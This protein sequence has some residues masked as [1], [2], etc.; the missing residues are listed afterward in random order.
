MIVTF[1]P[2]INT[3]A[4]A[5]AAYIN[6]LRCVTAACTAAVGAVAG[7]AN[8]TPTTTNLS[9]VPYLNNTGSQD[10]SKNCII[11]VDAN[12]E[13]GGWTTSSNHTLPSSA[14]FTAVNSAAAY[15]YKADFYN[16][17]GKATYPYNKLSFYTLG[18]SSTTYNAAP[19][20]VGG[21]WTVTSNNPTL[22]SWNSYPHIRMVFGSSVNSAW[23]AGDSYT[24]VGL[25]T[26]DNG[27]T[28][29]TSWS[30]NTSQQGLQNAHTA[31]FFANNTSSVY[32]IA[33]TSNY[34]I[35]WQQHS[36]N[37]YASGY[38]N[39]ITIPTTA[40]PV[41][42]WGLYGHMMYG[43]L[44]ET[45][46][47]E[48]SY[49]DNPPW[50]AFQYLSG[51]ISTSLSS[52]FTVAHNF[53]AWMRTIDNNG[54]VSG[55]ATRYYLSNTYQTSGSGPVFGSNAAS[56]TSNANSADPY[57]VG[58]NPLLGLQSPPWYGVDDGTHNP[59][60]NTFPVMPT[61]DPAT[62]TLVP[63]AYPIVIRRN[64][65]GSFNPG[66]AVRGIYKSL[67]M[68]LATL[69]LY[70]GAANQTFTIGNDQYIPIVFGS[71]DMFLIRYA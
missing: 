45:Q 32:K 69:K 67:T 29:T 28:Q 52:T 23:T 57:A 43:G 36:N 58:Y 20:T 48:N 19:S 27:G 40:N 61:V 11:S 2:M 9:V 22:S 33:V 50:V 53:G 68:P 12:S 16:S 21:Y 64:V 42:G 8:S 1:N 10:V 24:P 66:G 49:S 38:T 60:T 46:T 41:S 17:S 55:S 37:S 3:S 14:T 65:S 31:G 56:S 30:L 47:W 59:G 4:T 35:V 62:G 39:T 54:V 70:W 6:F 15:A 51:N 63:S 13:A 34:C 18:Q 5:D 7:T 26:P 25:T 44:R 71:G